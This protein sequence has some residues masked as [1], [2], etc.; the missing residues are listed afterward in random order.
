MV[1]ENQSA[2][3]LAPLATLAP[4]IAVSSLVIGLNLAADGLAKALGIDRTHEVRA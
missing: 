1:A 3:T 4:L 2:M